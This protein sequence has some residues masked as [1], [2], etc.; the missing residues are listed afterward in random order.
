MK[1][2]ESF[3]LSLN[4]IKDILDLAQLK[5]IRHEK[6]TYGLNNIFFVTKK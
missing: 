1:E 2:G 6:F 4:Q 3:G 5:I